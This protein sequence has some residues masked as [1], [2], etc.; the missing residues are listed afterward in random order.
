MRA[1][2]TA[3]ALALAAGA[4][5]AEDQDVRV[6]IVL[7]DGKPAGEFRLTVHTGDDGTETVTAT[8]AVRV[9]LLL[10][11]YH[12]HLQ[13][14]EVWTGGRLRSL[15]AASDDDGTK[16]AIRATATADGLRVT[17]DGREHGAR[18]DAWPTTYWRLPAALRA[19]Q[20]LPLLDV[21][22]GRA[23]TARLVPVGPERLTVGG[24]TSDVSHYRV[25]GQAQAELWYDGRGRLVREETVEDGHKTVLELRELGR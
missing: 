4:A 5:R 1:W 12:Y 2:M 18:P 9:K 22:T 8:A 24:R 14:T 21:D 20:P 6:F 15:D 3:L 23:L 13:S 10:G 7:V 16:H 19:G 11:S 17:A 25:S